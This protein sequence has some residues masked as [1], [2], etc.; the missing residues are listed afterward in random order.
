MVVTRVGGL[1]EI[2]TDG[3]SGYVTDTTPQAI[4]AAIRDFF[5][6]NRAEAMRRG[7]Q[8]EKK[9]FSWEHLAATVLGK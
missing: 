4:A 6:N 1:P 7:V 2:V 8:T 3:I 5:A 9:R